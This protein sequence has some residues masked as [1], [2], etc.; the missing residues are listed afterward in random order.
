MTALAYI[1]IVAIPMTA[2]GTV[3]VALRRG[4]PRPFQGCST[5]QLQ[6]RLRQLSPAGGADAA[7]KER[8][9]LEDELFRR[10]QWHR[11]PPQGRR[12]R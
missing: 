1:L 6:G 12:R 2:L 7:D 10:G 3:A 4:R 5:E 9:R 8:R 11:E